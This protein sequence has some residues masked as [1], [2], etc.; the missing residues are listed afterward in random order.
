MSDA[1][2][3]LR[4]A[5]DDLTDFAAD[6]DEASSWV[7]TRCPGWAVRDLVFHLLGDAQRALVAL[8]TP[9]AGGADRDAVSYWVTAPTGSDPESR[10]IRAQRTMA[11]AW[12]LDYLI[13]TYRSTAR[14]VLHL[15]ERT[16]GDQLVQTQGHVLRVGDLCATLA[17]EAAVHHL[18][19]VVFMDHPGPSA[20]PLGLVRKTLDGLLGRPA[21][22]PCDDRTWAL[23]G[24]GRQPPTE[25][26][27]A[28]LG[29]DADRLPLLG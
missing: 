29:A 24:S 21:P 22:F 25:K 17:V 18:D 27:R 7:P 16:P 19:L 1:L 12:R 15:A 4:E 14:A 20:G 28:A 9:A 10:E 2:S 8:A 6:L 11:S 13:E 26:Q 3:V 23:I 5:Y